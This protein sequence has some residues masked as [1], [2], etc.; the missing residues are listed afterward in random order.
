MSTRVVVVTGG[1]QGIGLGVSQAF[2]RTGWHVVIADVDEEAGREAM[3]FFQAQ[4]YLGRFVRTDVSDEGQVK[5]LIASISETEGRLDVVVNN[6]GVF[7]GGPIEEL[8]V[9]VF[10]RVIAVNLRG[11]FLMAKYSA[12]LLRKN[13][14]G[15]IINMASTRALMSEPNTEPYSASK[16][17]IVALTHALSISLGPDIRVNCISPGWIE[18]SD[19]KKSKNRTSPHHRE[20][21]KAQHPV[22]RVGVPN[23]IASLC[24]FLASNESSFIT[25]QNFV[26]DGGIT[27]KMIYEPD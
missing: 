25:G 11:P 5:S 20:V 12:P 10:D 1:A 3:S 17:G 2:A 19:W 14:P 22:G 27:K 7:S 18:V 16:G 8:P 9:D 6:A 4:S 26:V 15:V 21:D 24:L 13:A 23:D